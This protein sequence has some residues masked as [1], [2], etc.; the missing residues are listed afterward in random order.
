MINKIVCGVAGV[1]SI[2][3]F[4]KAFYNYHLKQIVFGKSFIK[5]PSSAYAEM[6]QMLTEEPEFR[7]IVESHP[8]IDPEIATDYAIVRIVN[9]ANPVKNTLDLVLVLE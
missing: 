1:I 3:F 2:G 8:R 5:L 9:K 6:R 4:S 7:K